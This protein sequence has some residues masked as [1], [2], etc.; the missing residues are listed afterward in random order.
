[1]AEAEQSIFGQIRLEDMRAS[2]LLTRTVLPLVK[3]ALE[4]SDGRYSL[5]N[6]ID[7]LREG[8]FELWGVMRL[9]D[10]LQGV[11]VTH[12][13]TYPSGARAYT[14][15]HLGGPTMADAAAFFRFLPRME[16]VA[17]GARCDRLVMVGRRGWER[18]LDKE[19]RVVSTV[20]ERTLGPR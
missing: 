20:Y 11:A 3:R 15:L 2:E 19:W 9:P 5:D 1:M 4:H 8:K 16:A 6:I 14:I 13:E 10:H 7:G 17:R 12:V 18:D